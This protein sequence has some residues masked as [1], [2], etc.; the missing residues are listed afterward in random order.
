MLFYSLQ[1]V[2]MMP[3]HDTRSGFDQSAGEKDLT[4]RWLEH[5]LLTPMQ[6]HDHDVVLTRGRNDINKYVCFYNQRVWNPVTLVVC[7]GSQRVPQQ[8]NGRSTH[9]EH[10][11]PARS[12]CPAKAND[13]DPGDLQSLNRIFK[14]IDSVLQAVVVC[15]VE[16][17]E[18]RGPQF[19]D[20]SG[21][22]AK[23]H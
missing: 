19:A 23:L 12:G 7:L 6:R 17:I 18:S 2:G 1:D 14:G 5:E 11:R 8:R 15:H 20:C 4:A 9:I 16:S 10:T 21:R 13:A 3:E 22:T